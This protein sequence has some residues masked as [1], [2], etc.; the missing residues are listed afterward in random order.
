MGKE[1]VS[2]II[3]GKPVQAKAGDKLL[4]AA[5][6]AGIYIPN[7]CAM[8]GIQPQAGCRLCFVEVEGQRR[9]ITACTEEVVEGMNVK[10]D[11][12]QVRRL[13]RT[14]LELLLASH[15]IECKT[16]PANGKCELQKIASFLKV[17]LKQ[18]RFRDKVRHLPIDDSHPN[19]AIDPNKCV[20]CGKCIWACV[21]HKGIGAINWAFRGDRTTISAFGGDR[22]VDT[23]CNGDG[24][25]ADVCPV[26]AIYRKQ[27]SPTITTKTPKRRK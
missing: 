1:N 9:P 26:G 23:K 4:F 8:R 18:K 24:L 14:A 7:L 12:G 21:E 19:I 15:P 20:I 16:C 13:Q 25:C 17:K 5:L 6:D 2:I 22:L 11:S 27:D 10:T 3:D